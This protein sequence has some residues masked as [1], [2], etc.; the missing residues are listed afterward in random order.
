MLLCFKYYANN[1]Y[2][3]VLFA[4]IVYIDE[5]YEHIYLNKSFIL[6]VLTK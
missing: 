4:L 1:I 5:K 2:H 6:I 3:F